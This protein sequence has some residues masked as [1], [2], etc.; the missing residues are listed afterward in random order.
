MG[1]LASLKSVCVSLDGEQDVSKEVLMEV[2][3]KLRHEA[4]VHPNDPSILIELDV[5]A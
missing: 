4:D 3:E 1:H 5:P 2:E